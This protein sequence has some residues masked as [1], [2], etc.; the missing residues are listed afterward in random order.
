MLA[1]ARSGRGEPLLL[2]HGIGSRREVWDPVIGALSTAHDVIAL[3]LPGFGAS[4][5][6]DGPTNVAT[7]TDAVVAFAAELGLPR[8][9]VA[10]N[11]MGGAIALELAARGAVASATAVSPAGFWSKRERRYAQS[12]LAQVR[13]VGRRLRD[14]GA[15]P[16]LV[17]TRAGRTLLFGQTFGRPWKLTPEDAIGTVDAFVDC[18]GWDEA[19]ASFVG[20]LAPWNHGDVP[21]TI[22]WGTHDWLLLPR[23]GRRARTVMPR[24]RHVWLDGCGHAPFSDDP[25]RVAAVLLAG[26][27]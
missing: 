15:I 14:A 12:T 25:E 5:R 21:V 19:F 9:H 17:A 20:Y 22:A 7:L 6:L 13:V 23:Q 10:G 11:S 2:V 4:P 27:R 26:T 16:P 8:W 3:D 24:A 18:P 1:H